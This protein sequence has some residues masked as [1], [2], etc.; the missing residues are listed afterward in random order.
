MTVK[1]GWKRYRGSVD[2]KDS[3]ISGDT[4][5]KIHELKPGQSPLLYIDYIDNQYPD[6]VE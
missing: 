5:D 6:K 2:E 1:K 3:L 4:F